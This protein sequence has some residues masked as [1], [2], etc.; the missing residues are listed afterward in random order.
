MLCFAASYDTRARVPQCL[1]EK[2]T[3]DT[4]ELLKSLFEKT[5][6]HELGSYELRVVQKLYPGMQMKTFYRV[7]MEEK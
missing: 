4:T 3:E 2:Q 5:V 6:I 1:G 7:N